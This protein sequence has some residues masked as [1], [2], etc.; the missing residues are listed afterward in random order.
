MVPKYLTSSYFECLHLQ[1]V[2][3]SVEDPIMK[4]DEI[5]KAFTKVK[6]KKELNMQI[7]QQHDYYKKL[8]CNRP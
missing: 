4:N 7:Y 5:Q 6:K 1:C 3:E 8:K 2:I